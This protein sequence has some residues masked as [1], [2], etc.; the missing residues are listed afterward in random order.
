MS[1]L[2]NPRKLTNFEILNTKQYQNSKLKRQNLSFEFKNLI[3][4]IYLSF[5][6]CHLL[7]KKRPS[8]ESPYIV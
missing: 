3:F 8:L 2:K 7:F 5:E 1:T 4:E 6:F